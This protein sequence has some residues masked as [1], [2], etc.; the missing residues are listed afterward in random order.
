MTDTQIK[1][2]FALA[3]Q[4]NYTK[5]ARLLGISQSTP[6]THIT[7]LEKSMD[8][9]LFVRNRRTVS[10]SPEGEIMLEALKETEKIIKTALR[11]AKDYEKD[12]ILRIG[13]LEGLNTRMFSEKLEM[14]FQK[15]H[16]EIILDVR[17]F[18]GSE[19]LET[20]DS[21]EVDA[22]LGYHR[23]L[24][25]RRELNGITV[26]NSQMYLVKSSDRADRE[27][28]KEPGKLKDEYFILQEKEQDP[29]FETYF[30]EFCEKYAVNPEHVIRVS[31]IA[32]VMMNMEIGLG[33]GLIDG[34]SI[35]YQAPA[36]AFEKVEG[37]MVTYD[38]IYKSGRKKNSLRTLIEALLP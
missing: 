9:R 32:S 14:I 3:R 28:L 36:Y 29:I 38:L 23:L 13:I 6:S 25:N 11:K 33:V 34:F 10:L 19:L 31:N 12:N 18:G 21:G 1:C 20:F 4:L 5:A 24:K 17:S 27:L 30:Q 35:I 26:F 37:M 15:E 7:S 16:P 8:L 22:I 2:F